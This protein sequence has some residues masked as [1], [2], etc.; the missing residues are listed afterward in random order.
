MT[1]QQKRW[2]GA[3]QDLDP[4]T[5]RIKVWSTRAE[6]E[7]RGTTRIIGGLVA[8]RNPEEILAGGSISIEGRSLPGYL[9]LSSCF[10]YMS[11]RVFLS[12]AYCVI[13]SGGLQIGVFVPDTRGLTI[14]AAED[15]VVHPEADLAIV[16]VVD[17]PPP[18]PLFQ[19]PE[20]R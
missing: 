9:F 2:L 7:G 3:R 19:I 14:T 17:A 6:E 4:G 10:A 18:E 12:A 15:V 16:R 11:P 5:P 1:R 8:L 13:A 20:Q